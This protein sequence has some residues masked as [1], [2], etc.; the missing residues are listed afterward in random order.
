[1][2]ALF[3]AKSMTGWRSSWTIAC[4]P[5]QQLRNMSTIVSLEC[6][7]CVFPL[8]FDEYLKKWHPKYK[9]HL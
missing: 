9:N 6:H 1:M 4:Q 3:F 2:V 8:T 5:L 7:F